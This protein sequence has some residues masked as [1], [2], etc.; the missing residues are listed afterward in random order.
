M[1]WATFKGN[2]ESGPS[3]DL[4]NR[5]WWKWHRQFQAWFLRGARIFHFCDLQEN[6]K[7]FIKE[8]HP[9]ADYMEGPWGVGDALRPH[10]E[11]GWTPTTP[12]VTCFL[13]VHLL[14]HQTQEHTILAILTSLRSQKT[15]DATLSLGAQKDWRD[16]R[17]RGRRCSSGFLRNVGNW[18]RST[19]QIYLGYQMITT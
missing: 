19:S 17:L 10:G 14:R 16:H 2:C 6:S 18:N 5:G 7:S 1:T 15:A 8:V 9:P 11:G 3:C 12:A 4:T 13:A